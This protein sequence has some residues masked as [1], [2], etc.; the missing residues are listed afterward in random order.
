MNTADKSLAQID[1]ALRRRFEFIEMPPQPELLQGVS[2]FGVDLDHLLETLNSRIEILLDRD[3]LLGHAYFWPVLQATTSESRRIHLAQ[4]FRLK[5][6]PLLQ[7]YFYADW[8]RIRWV[9]NDNA[10]PANWQFI[11]TCDEPSIER[12]FSSDVASQLTDRRYRINDKAFDEAESY[13]WIVA[14]TDSI[15]AGAVSYT[16]LTLPTKRIV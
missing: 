2:V 3:H 8:E 14:N 15:D 5:I 4:T 9:L 16:H 10:K 11:T 13:Q 1:L 12:L 6:I 7:E